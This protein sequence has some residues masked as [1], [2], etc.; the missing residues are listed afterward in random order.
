MNAHGSTNDWVWIGL[1]ST[2]QGDSW[3]SPAS[4]LVC[5]GAAA[6]VAL[7][8]APLAALASGRGAD[9]VRPPQKYEVHPL[10]L[11]GARCRVTGIDSGA[12][13]G[14]CFTSDGAARAFVWTEETG[15]VDIGTLG[16]SSAGAGAIDRGRVAGSSNISGDLESHAFKWTAE[17]GMLD[18]GTLG[19]PFAGASSISEGGVV[20]ESA[21]SEGDVHAFLWTASTGMIDLP[22]LRGGV[23]SSAAEIDGDL[24]AGWS[25]TDVP[26]RRPVAWRTNGE[27]I[28]LVDEPIELGGIFVRG[29]GQATAVRNGL[30][31]GHRRISPSEESRAFAWRE[32]R[33]LIDL[34]LVPGSSESFALD[35]D[36]ELV[37]GQLSGVGGPAGFTTRAFVWTV[38]GGMRAITPSSIRAWAT[39]V[40]D[41]QVLGIYHTTPP[42]GGRVF[43][44]TKRKGL[45]DVLP[46][47]FPGGFAPVG[48]DA[49]GRIAVVFEDEDPANTRSVVLVPR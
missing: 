22:R 46:R 4:W 48:I 20:G 29:D 43:L 38:E 12:A 25:T 15:V 41:G 35:T 6:G 36:G 21:T 2:I 9:P 23:E 45:V 34:G 39:H 13:V 40:V 26:G 16:G 7:A 27:L 49:A 5:L 44:W 8:L 31:V 30:V 18:L 3:G 37:V 24:I 33:G 14:A 1:F 42:N 32:E 10:T 28:D 17:S 11:N 19:G 47:D